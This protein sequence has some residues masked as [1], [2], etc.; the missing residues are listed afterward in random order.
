MRLVVADTSAWVALGNI[1][2]RYHKRAAAFMAEIIEGNAIIVSP[3][4]VLDETFTLLMSRGLELRRVAGLYELM[5]RNAEY[6]T[7]RL[8]SVDKALF[9]KAWASFQRF[10][11]QKASFT[12]CVVYET[13]RAVKADCVFAFDEH[14]LKMGCDTRPSGVAQ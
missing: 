5:K 11:E 6:G 8:T 7:L 14:F 2:D 10:Y 3:D 13:A 1:N 9:D 4:Y 12:D